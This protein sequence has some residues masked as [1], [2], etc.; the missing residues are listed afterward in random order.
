MFFTVWGPIGPHADQDSLFA[1][2]KMKETVYILSL[3]IILDIIYLTYHLNDNQKSA[4]PA[5]LSKFSVIYAKKKM[6]V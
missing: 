6:S 4:T 5:P 3:H 1:L 2:I